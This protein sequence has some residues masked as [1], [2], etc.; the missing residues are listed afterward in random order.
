MTLVFEYKKVISLSLAEV[1]RDISGQN[2]Q[3]FGRHGKI[4]DSNCIE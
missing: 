4:K 1:F 2:Q 3:A